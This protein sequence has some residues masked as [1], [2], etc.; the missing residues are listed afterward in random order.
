MEVKRLYN[1][2]IRFIAICI[3]ALMVIISSV[4]AVM[5]LKNKNNKFEE[6]LVSKNYEELYSYIENP[7]FSL[8]VFKSYIDYNFG[9][10]INIIDKAEKENEIQYKI[11]TLDGDKTIRLV[12]IDKKGKWLFDDYTYNW[13][14]NVPS[15]AQVY[16]EEQQIENNNGEV[17]INK[18]PF[19]VYNLKVA[20]ENC[21]PYLERVMSGQNL[22]IKLSISDDT[23]NKCRVSIE[24]YLK[25]KENAI[26]NKTIGD[27][28]YIDKSSGLYKE[29]LDEVEWLK[30]A[31][32][33]TSKNLVNLNLVKGT[34]EDG[35]LI[36]EAVEKWNVKIN[37]DGNIS[38]KVE[39]HKNLYSLVP[40]EKFI[41]H[42]IKTNK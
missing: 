36:V 5:M 1:K 31:D 42:Q 21:K 25:F 10:N 3:L 34:I 24:E 29:V 2:E 19:G 23:L 16:I 14:I 26:N 28:N 20:M 41:I 33:K 17:L 35:I 27:I 7:D 32:F 12:K 30:T 37:N 8:H 6:Y 40:G 4:F 22:S 11:K 18:I 13:G 15:N 39:E 38:E 9:S